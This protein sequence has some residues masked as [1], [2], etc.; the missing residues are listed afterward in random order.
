MEDDAERPKWESDERI[1]PRQLPV[2]Q[3]MEPEIRKIRENEKRRKGSAEKIAYEKLVRLVNSEKKLMILKQVENVMMATRPNLLSA[4]P[5]DGLLRSEGTF[6]SQPEGNLVRYCFFR[7]KQSAV[8]PTVYYIHGGGMATS[9]CFYAQYQA[10]ARMIAHK[11]VNVFLVDFRNSLTP[12]IIGNEYSSGSLSPYPGGL[13]DCVSGLKFLHA[14]HETFYTDSSRILVAG[15]SGGGNLALALGIRLKL[16]C[17][18]L[19]SGIY[20][21]CPY[22]LGKYPSP[23]YPSTVRN[24]GIVLY[25][26]SMTRVM[27]GSV[28]AYEKQDPCAWPMFATKEDLQNLP[29][30]FVSL[31]ECDPLRDEGLAFYRKCIR[32]GIPAQCREVLGSVHGA[33]LSFT[34]PEVSAQT[35]Q[36]IATFA[37][38]NTS[39][40]SHKSKL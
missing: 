28:S 9:S 23:D 6:I 22:I 26:G 18:D 29:P 34:M 8:R 5:L 12:G 31:N 30:V 27:Y 13:N 19:A 36:S 37:K 32:A 14:N 11:G 33:E 39:K 7:P 35:A 21:L 15:E 3:L 38:S 17:K 24:N 20:A 10:W 16:Q 40:P 4:A 1:D 2:L 25:L